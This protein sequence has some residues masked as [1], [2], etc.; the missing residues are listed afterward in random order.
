MSGIKTLALLVA[1]ACRC[2]IGE[3][4]VEYGN[5]SRYKLKTRPVDGRLLIML[6]ISIEQRIE[7]GIFHSSDC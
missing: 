4:V 3:D 6:V 7:N 2:F 5:E 1:S